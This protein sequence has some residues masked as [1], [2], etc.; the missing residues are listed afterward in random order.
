M[1]RDENFLCLDIDVKSGRTFK[2]SHFQEDSW[3]HDHE[4]GITHCVFIRE[5][6]L[7]I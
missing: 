2:L 1:K 5:V 7:Q 3:A 6:R 4:I